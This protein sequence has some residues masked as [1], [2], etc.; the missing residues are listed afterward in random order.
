MSQASLFVPAYLVS[1]GAVLFFNGLLIYTFYQVDNSNSMI[2]GTVDVNLMCRDVRSNTSI[3]LT[4]IHSEQKY[5]TIEF[6][7]ALESVAFY[8]RNLHITV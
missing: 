7:G 8:V 5:I 6:A 2:N 4:D 1:V 3:E